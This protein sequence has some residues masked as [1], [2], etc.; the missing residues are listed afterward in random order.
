MAVEFFNFGNNETYIFFC[1]IVHTHSVED[2][3]ASA[4][5]IAETPSPD[6]YD[7][8]DICVAVRG[9]LT[10]KLREIVHDVA[11]GLDPDCIGTWAIGAAEDN[12]NSPDSLLLPILALGLGRID[13]GAVAEALLI[14]AGKWSPSKVLPELI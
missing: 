8:E 7:G 9:R 12:Q 1:W 2:L 4:F 14:R 5:K 13:H 10:E 6:D 11:P 3:I